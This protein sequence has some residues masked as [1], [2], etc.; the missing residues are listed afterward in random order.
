MKKELKKQKTYVGLNKYNIFKKE[1]KKQDDTFWDPEIDADTLAYI[2]HNFIS[3]ED[4]Y[5]GKNLEEKKEKEKNNND[6]S[7]NEENEPNLTPIKAKE[8]FF[9]NDENANLNN[10][11]YEKEKQ[12][13]AEHG[14]LDKL[15]SE[16]NN[17]NK[18]IEFIAINSNVIKSEYPVNQKSKEELKFE[19][20]LKQDFKNKMN[21]ISEI[22]LNFFPRNGKFSAK[23][24]ERFLRFQSLV[25]KTREIEL[26]LGPKNS[27]NEESESLKEINE[28]SEIKLGQ[29]D[30]KEGSGDK[31]LSDITGKKS[32]LDG[33]KNLLNSPIN[34]NGYNKY[35]KKRV[36]NFNEG[37]SNHSFSSE[38]ANSVS[39]NEDDN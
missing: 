27:T 20:E 36:F 23:K 39:K 34:K 8:I 1:N 6:N 25:R 5:N 32:F 22:E 14:D 13:D 16:D 29:E 26:T 38:K 11:V 10:F 21:K 28:N 15:K 17:I 3:I 37:N 2:N 9:E 7:Q 31:S 24:I 4:I 35:G 30:N 18:F 12:Q 33:D 19:F